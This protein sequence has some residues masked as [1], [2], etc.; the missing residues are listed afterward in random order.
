MGVTLNWATAEVQ[1]GKL[2]VDLEGEVPSGWKKRFQTTVRLLG[3]GSWG[4]IACKK[5]AVRVT[6]VEPGDEEKLRHFLESAVTQANAGFQATE[7]DSDDVAQEDAPREDDSPD[8]VMTEQF[9]S[10]SDR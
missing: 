7:S 9:R 2:T 5:Q 8:T 1:D 6:Q 3:G 4:E 10:F